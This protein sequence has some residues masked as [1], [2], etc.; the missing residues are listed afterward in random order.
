MRTKYGIRYKAYNGANGLGEFTQT[1]N[2]LGWVDSK[3]E[4][5]ATL[6]AKQGWRNNNPNFPEFSAWIVTKQVKTRESMIL[7][8]N[9]ALS[10]GL[11][12]EFQSALRSLGY[13]FPENPEE[14]DD[15]MAKINQLPKKPLPQELQDPTQLLAQGRAKL[16]F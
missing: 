11:G 15:L 2:G 6:L 14:L 9:E 8:D 12:P 10:G 3:E 1:I 13:L 7:D 4:A 5:E 16:T